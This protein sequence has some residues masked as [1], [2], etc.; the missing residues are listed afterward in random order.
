M[1]EVFCAFLSLGLTSFGGPVAHLGYFRR[2]FV[3]KRKWLSEADYAAI[4]SLCQFLPG[5]A[6]SQTGFCIGL[7]R[8]GWRGGAAAWAGFTLPS[9]ITMFF[10][11]RET[12][13]FSASRLGA[14]ILHGL[15]LAAIA[16]VAQAVWTMSRSLCPDTPRRLLA[17][18]ALLVVA[19]MPGTL[20][21]LA[22]LVIGATVGKFFL[23]AAPASR[24]TNLI[25]ISRNAGALSLGG[26]FLLLLLAFLIRGHGDPALFGAF[27]RTGALVFGGGHV[28]LPLLHDAIVTPGWVSPGTFLAGYGAAQAMPGPLFTVAAYLG[29]LAST[30]SGGALGAAIAL[31]AIFLPG[32]LLVAGILPF[33][34]ELKQHPQ[35]AAAVTGLNA[36][37]VGLLGYALIGLVRFGTIHN[38]FNLAIVL[39]ALIALIWRKTPPI[40]VVLGCAAVSAF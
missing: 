16:V 40:F 5:P 17:L 33:W 9:A 27:Y 24:D 26:F 7:M 34:H 30:G 38:A 8:G 20:G 21:Q 23:Q 2:E 36:A 22:V 39:L 4:L 19:I 28:V 14:G 25:T 37:V 18:A 13:W 15:Q 32:L 3:E 10:I 12:A 31:I 35:I 1:V 29:A 6:S 11:A